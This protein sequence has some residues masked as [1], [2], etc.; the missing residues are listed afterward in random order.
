MNLV[1]GRPALSAAR[2]ARAFAKARAVC[3]GLA[4]LDTRWVHLV[5]AT[6]ALTTDETAQL[7]HMLTYGP[8]VEP[9]AP[10]G[11]MTSAPASAAAQRHVV[12]VTP[13]IGTTSPWSSKATDI[14]HVC[15]LAAIERIE[16]AIEYTL[17]GSGVDPAAIG[18]AL[19]DRMTESVIVDDREL[20]RVVHHGSEPR[21]LAFVKLPADETAARATLKDAS[22]RMGLALAGDEIEYLVARY[23]ELGRDPTDVELMMFAQANSEH[24][25]HKIFNADFF[26]D[27][28]RQDR[29]LFQ[30]IKATNAASPGGVLS[31]YKDNAAVVEGTEAER[32]FPAPD[33]VY[34][35][36]REPSHIL[37]KVETHNH[38]T[39]ISPHPGAATGSGGEIRDEGATGRGAKPKAG[40]VGFTV[41]DLRLPGALEPWE[42]PDAA[43]VGKPARIAS[44]LDIMIEG[45]I[46]GAAFNNEFGRPAIL[47]Y[48]RAYEHEDR[49]YHKPVM[50]AGGIGAIRPGHVQKASVPTGAALVVL[51]GPAFLIGLGGGA[52]SSVAQG[53]SHEELDFASVQRDNAEIE[54]R[55]Q[56]VIDRCWALGDGN[57]VLSIHDVG[58]GGLSNALPELVHDAGLGARL[59]LRAI[60]TG[61]PE[62]SPLEL[63]CNEA[64]ERYVLAIAAE[65]LAEFAALCA[66]ERAPW[67]QLGTAS[68]DGRLV[69]AD[70]RGGPAPVDLPLEVVLGKPPR[71][72]RRAETIA[73]RR[74]PLRL[75]GVTIA[76]ALDRVLGMPTVADKSFLVTIG[77]RTVGGLV[78]RDSMVGP[79][80]VPVADCALTLAG[81]DTTAG[82]VMA[83][84]ERPPVA[85]LDA[86]A[87]SRLAIAE[88]ITNLAAAPIG[89]LGRIKLSCNWMAAAGH[90]GED[91]RLY[92]AV[93]AAAET[94]IALGISIPVGKDSM[95][96]RTVWDAPRAINTPAH[97][98]DAAMT[99]TGDVLTPAQQLAQLEAEVAAEPPGPPADP[100][101]A[102]LEALARERAKRE[103]PPTTFEP[104]VP[105]EATLRRQRARDEA[106]ALAAESK[107][108]AALASA[109]T[110]EY[111]VSGGTSGFVAQGP[112]PG[113]RAIVSPVTLVVTAFG[114]VTDVR[115]A[116][117]PELR[118]GDRQLLLVDLAAG[119]GRLGGSCLAQAFDQL[120]DTPPDLDDP[121]RLLAVYGALQELVAARKLAAYHDR[122][123]GGLV[124]TALEMAFAS[125]LGLE[126]DVTHVHADP[127]AALFAEELGALVEVATADVAAVRGALE[128]AGARIVPLGRAV[129]GERVQITHG[130]QRVIEARRSELRARWSHVSHQIALLRD[131]AACAAEEHASRLAEI[132]LSAELT[133]DLARPPAIVGTARPRVAILR[134]QGVNG[135]IEMAA[136]FTRA[137]F[138]AV[139]IHMTDLVEGRADLSDMR[140]AVAC[141]GFSFGDVLGAGRGWA[142]TFRYNAR[143]RDALAKL[144]ARDGTFLLGVCNG[145]QALADL[146]D[147]LPGAA[148]WPK[149]VR[150]RSEQF[151]ARVVLLR[152]EDSPSIFFR[153]MAGSRIPVANAHGEGRAELSAD[154]L[155]AM[156]RAGL[157]AARFVDGRG[158]VATT[159]PAN[160]NG[161]PGGVA[162]L[163]TADGRIT[164]LMPHPERVFRTVQLSWHPDG[165]G[166]DSPWMRMF[167]N[168]R[169][170]V[171]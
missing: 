71:M 133:F 46:G 102:E 25:R 40:L 171:A 149:F 39:A 112:D 126:L 61:E 89:P 146:A 106:Y 119:Q 32:F 139:D 128:A 160:P 81:F 166:E 120:G 157:V 55:C 124:V 87:A 65:R 111:R 3:P 72:T 155:A 90:P 113:K 58:A 1:P 14:A 144:T 162:A 169:A 164:I 109:D 12:Y 7:Q 56:E 23:R 91:A 154:Q 15:G 78:A 29:S 63:W 98:L 159:Y 141:G 95:S 42:S 9:M 161:S 80:Q 96:M 41:S 145:C 94:A 47:G 48:F 143:A 88:A 51:G 85:L 62:L 168:A 100:E 64:Q 66:R 11:A 170:W 123:D 21:P 44:A 68:P 26:V 83:I 114:P 43:W 105:D 137:G 163:T 148:A 84:G 136:A 116:V 150:N 103:T 19:S 35:G 127:F 104:R 130:G 158:A 77:D 153:G 17:Y 33:G 13:R 16:R 28:E 152:I 138:D 134:E 10:S 37:G 20:E 99:K 122:S 34:R 82:E 22:D 18:R 52:A 38:P 140:G 67:A 53:A 74:H 135:Q 2:R 30:M 31:A 5:V 69:L 125:G 73:P 50:L 70:R 45:P 101:L 147:L 79:F 75:D 117:T 156:E 115:L 129:P 54:R 8:H 118:G 107:I 59:E 151:E 60:P 92:Q 131:D 4:M 76:S 97:G 165:W 86:A 121:K 108:A 132:P 93:R 167:D 6:R 36:V 24:C 49:G 110:M 57:P 142:S 27:G